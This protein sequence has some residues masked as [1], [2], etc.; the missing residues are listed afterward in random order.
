MSLACILLLPV[1]YSVHFAGYA[2]FFDF[3]EKMKRVLLCVATE[4]GS[5]AGNLLILCFTTRFNLCTTENV[6][7]LV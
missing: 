7:Y 4:I 5:Y 2:S 6:S 1:Y 3:Y